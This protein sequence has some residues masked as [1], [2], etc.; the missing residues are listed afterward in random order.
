[1]IALYITYTHIIHDWIS[2]HAEAKENTHSAVNRD[3][4]AFRKERHFLSCPVF[5]YREEK[6][7]YLACHPFILTTPKLTTPG[8]RDSESGIKSCFDEWKRIVCIAYI[9]CNSERKKKKRKGSLYLPRRICVCSSVPHPDLTTVDP[10]FF[11]PPFL[12][13]FSL[14]RPAYSNPCF[15]Y[16]AHDRLVYTIIAM[17]LLTM[18]ACKWI[19]LEINT[20]TFLS[21]YGNNGGVLTLPIVKTDLA[22][23]LVTLCNK[24]CTSDKRSECN[25]TDSWEK[26][27]SLKFTHG[28]LA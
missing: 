9:F 14:F 15:F 4:K 19:Y 25:I 7:L 1:M 28:V 26:R 10:L 6:Y 20:Y 5:A 12:S 13:K 24:I 3:C 2:E 27:N 18:Y 8:V 21:L 22:F 16:C 17:V 23:E 11:L